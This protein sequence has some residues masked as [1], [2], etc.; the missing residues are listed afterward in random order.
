MKRRKFTLARFSH[1]VGAEASGLEGTQVERSSHTLQASLL[2]LR[3][4]TTIAGAASQA[5]A[6]MPAPPT[7]PQV[8]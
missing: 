5:A 6:L 1:H 8:C 4:A 2:R 3:G 7:A